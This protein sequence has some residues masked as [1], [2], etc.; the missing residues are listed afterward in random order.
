[1]LAITLYPQLAGSV[2]KPS[3]TWG[4]ISAAFTEISTFSSKL[5][6]PVIEILPFSILFLLFKLT[7]RAE[8]QVTV[9]ETSQFF[10]IQ[11]HSHHFF[12]VCAAL[13][14]HLFIHLFIPFLWLSIY[15]STHAMH[16][17][18]LSVFTHL[19]NALKMHSS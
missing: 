11:F 4:G 17:Y 5:L 3:S 2:P 8:V 13:Y 15:P 16:T 9:I 19:P 7:R 18:H 6:W 14:I 1:M 10:L 12:S